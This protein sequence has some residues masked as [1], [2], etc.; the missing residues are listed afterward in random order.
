MAFWQ[1]NNIEPKRGYRFILSIPG[2]GGAGPGGQ[3][4]TGIRQY[5]IKSVKKPGWTV[6][7]QDVQYLNHTFHYPGR[8]TWGPVSFEIVDTVDV[9]SNGT[10]ELMKLLQD[11]GYELP[12]PVGTEGRGL[13]SISKA[14]ATSTL[15]QVRIKTLDADGLVVEEWVLNN[16]WIS[17]AEF[18]NLS[19]AEEGILNVSVSLQYDNAY[20]EFDGNKVPFTSG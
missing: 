13:K 12:V 14:N 10:V 2:S 19:Y 7:N 5:L 18:G 11:A 8:V 16:A 9:G 6:A 1:D 15:G 3:P 4:N 17:A 20:V